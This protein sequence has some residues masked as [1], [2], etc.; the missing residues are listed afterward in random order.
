MK[1][2]LAWVAFVTS[3]AAAMGIRFCELSGYASGTWNVM[4][5]V[6]CIVLAAGCIVC[7]FVSRRDHTMVRLPFSG[8]VL[9]IVFILSGILLSGI[10]V[11]A[12]A[13]N[14][15]GRFPYTTGICTLLAVFAGLIL[16]LQGCLFAADGQNFAAEHPVLTKW[17]AFWCFGELVLQVF[18]DLSEP[19]TSGHILRTGALFFMTLTLFSLAQMDAEARRVS[20]GRLFG[21]GFP[22][23]LFAAV[24]VCPEIFGAPVIYP[25]GMQWTLL[26]I[27]TFITF[28][29]LTVRPMTREELTGET[30]DMEEPEVR[31]VVM[32]D[33]PVLLSHRMLVKRPVIASRD[34]PRPLSPNEMDKRL[35]RV[36]VQ[37]LVQSYDAKCYFYR[38]KKD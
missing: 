1:L 23:V 13:R 4:S 29:L 11:V 14:K 6:L 19:L 35:E 21:F 31:P 36:L 16:C 30:E 7:F 27:G 9:S 15:T 24:S 26:V 32:K 17:P 8:R 38:R 37:Y 25:Q 34:D 12:Q 5:E 33:S 10:A 2:K 18:V 28:S 3:L 20:R 22:A